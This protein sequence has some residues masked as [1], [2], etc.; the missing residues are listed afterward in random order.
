MLIQ[1]VCELLKQE[2]WENGYEYGFFLDGITHKPDMTKGFDKKFFERLFWMTLA[3][4]ARYG[5]YM[6]SKL[7]VVPLPTLS[8]RYFALCCSDSINIV[9]IKWYN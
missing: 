7:K 6:I 3:F 1:E 4:Q 9:P 5:Y 8:F 2:L